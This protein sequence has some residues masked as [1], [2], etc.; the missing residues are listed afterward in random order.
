MSVLGTMASIERQAQEDNFVNRRKPRMFASENPV[1][2]P[3]TPYHL[4]FC[5]W[6][7]SEA[8]GNN[9]RA[10]IEACGGTWLTC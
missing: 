3:E 6:L 1:S 8:F 10:L 9:R 4:D 2:S 7:Q 5:A